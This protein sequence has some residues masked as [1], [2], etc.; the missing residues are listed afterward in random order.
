MSREVFNRREIQKILSKAAEF[1]MARNLD[2]HANQ[3]TK[4]ELIN[5]ASEAGISPESIKSAL[6]SFDAPEFEKT[7][8]WLKGTS[9]IQ[10]IEEFDTPLESEKSAK[11]L[12]LLQ[13]MENE[14]GETELHSKKMEWSSQR[15]A[16]LIKVSLFEENGKT[17]FTY[18]NDWTTIKFIVGVFPFIL[19]SMIIL[20]IT[21]GMGFDKFTS[22]LFAPFGGLLALGVSWIYLKHRFEKQRNKLN[23]ILDQIRALFL[24]NRSESNSIEID[25]ESTEQKQNPTNQQKIRA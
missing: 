7:F 25:E 22:L 16:E 10:Y 3:L 21:K 23:S 24:N 13:S 19:V 1:E 17:S 15:E 5:L 18:S 6:Y 9:R 11:V 2:D 14:L 20:I 12:R 4:Q 8:S